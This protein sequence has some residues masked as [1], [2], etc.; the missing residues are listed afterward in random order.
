MS[1]IKN[2]ERDDRSGVRKLAIFKAQAI[3]TCFG[4][5]SLFD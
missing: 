5:K 1:G 4:M 2:S 3:K